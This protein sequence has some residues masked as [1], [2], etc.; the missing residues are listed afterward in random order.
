[1]NARAVISN[2]TRDMLPPAL[3]RATRSAAGLA[4]F[5]LTRQPQLL[6]PSRSLAG[7]GAGRRAFVCATGPSLRREDLAALAGEDC[8]SLSNFFLH[9][10]LSVIRP[11]FQFFLPYHPPLILDNYIEWLRQADQRLPPETAL[12]LSH[13]SAPL[14]RRY[15]LFPRRQI[16]YV[17]L[18]RHHRPR[19]I[20]LDGPILAPASVPLLALPVLLAMGYTTI[21]L[22]GCDHTGLRDYGG[23][24]THF[25]QPGQDVRKNASDSGAWSDI[26]TNHAR[27][28]DVF[29]QYRYYRTMI[30]RYYPQTRVVNLSQDS[31]LDLFPCDRLDRVLAAREGAADA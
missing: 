7:R 4:H 15:G 9:E 14:V 23:S 10:A 13:T 20:S 2:L 1:M 30:A 19:R 3:Y 27:S 16:F 6:A 26:I 24:V 21:Y 5:L 17:F 18:T 29:L 12:L 8:F 25:Y 28:L 11:Q 31:W 22:L